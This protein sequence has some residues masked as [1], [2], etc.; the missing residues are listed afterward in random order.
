MHQKFKAAFLSGFLIYWKLDTDDT[1]NR[2]FFDTFNNLSKNKNKFAKKIF[3]IFFLSLVLFSNSLTFELD[4]YLTIVPR[5]LQ[6]TALEILYYIKNQK[7]V[8][9]H[10]LIYILKEKK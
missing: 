8:P 7:T 4:V 9:T 6:N 5:S 2:L 10:T 3:N 1:I